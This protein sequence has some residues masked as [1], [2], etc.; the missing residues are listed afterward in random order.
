M[1]K[2]DNTI[3]LAAYFEID[4]I[5]NNSVF[6]VGKQTDIVAFEKKLRKIALSIPGNENPV[7]FVSSQKN[8]KFEIGQINKKPN[9]IDVL[10]G[11]LDSDNKKFIFQPRIKINKCGD[12][13]YVA[14]KNHTKDMYDVLSDILKKI[15]DDEMELVFDQCV[16]DH[17]FGSEW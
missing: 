11:I 12:A 7:F 16:L 4:G 10:F 2:K 13:T 1:E 9:M 3:G 15:C 5:G 14:L 6:K 17:F 8:I